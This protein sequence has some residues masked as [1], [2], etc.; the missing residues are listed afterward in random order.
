MAAIMALP[1]NVVREE[2][3]TQVSHDDLVCIAKRSAA[4][5]GMSLEDAFDLYSKGGR[6][7]GYIWDDLSTIFAAMILGA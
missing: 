7:K 4:R 1:H 5:L 6:A 3:T 2:A